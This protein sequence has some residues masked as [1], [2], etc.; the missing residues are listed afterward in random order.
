M[1]CLSTSRQVLGGGGAFYNL[2]T[3][4]ISTWHFP[5][6]VAMDNSFQAES[7]VAW[8]VLRPT[9]PG[10]RWVVVAGDYKDPSTLTFCDS[11][12]YMSALLGKR[13]YEMDDL[14]D[15]TIQVC[16][17]LIVARGVCVRKHLYSHVQGT[18]LDDL[19]DVADAA[20]KKGAA[21]ACLKVGY[22]VGLQ[23]PQAVVTRQGRQ[24]HT[25]RSRLM[26]DLEVWYH[27][28]HVPSQPMPHFGQ[29]AEVVCHAGITIEDHTLLLA[30]RHG[31]LFTKPTTPCIPCGEHPDHR[32]SITSCAMAWLY[33]LHHAYNPARVIPTVYDV[34][35]LRV[36]MEFGVLVLYPPGCF[37]LRVVEWAQDPST[38][39]VRGLPDPFPVFS[40]GHTGDVTRATHLALLDKG[41]SQP[42]FLAI[43]HTVVQHTA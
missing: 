31:V 25:L 40:I 20:A 4:A 37:L 22:L 8:V 16:R 41:I 9:P 21:D 33:W 39:T 15:A 35:H 17:A 13:K 18:L 23:F 19:L 30:I 42:M 12:S 3:E 5:I 1:M 32:A 14:V 2:D 6:P 38:S 11:L 7:Y 34:W 26:S 43:L 27:G 24:V 36:P 28:R 29:Y 10:V